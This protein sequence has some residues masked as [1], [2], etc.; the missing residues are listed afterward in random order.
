[1]HMLS[2][3]GWYTW[4][5]HPQFGSGACVVVSWERRLLSKLYSHRA[6]FNDNG[7]PATASRGSG[8][9][10]AET[11]QRLR[12]WGSQIVLAEGFETGIP[13]SQFSLSRDCGFFWFAWEHSN[14]LIWLRGVEAETTIEATSFYTPAYKE[15]LADVIVI[16]ASLVYWAPTS[17]ATVPTSTLWAEGEN[18]VYAFLL[19]E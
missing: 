9:V 14:G 12:S 8:P 5:V 17:S 18:V 1:M 4:F 11:A 2:Y 19:Q 13:L 7:R 6:L 3:R 15:L 10:A 16:A